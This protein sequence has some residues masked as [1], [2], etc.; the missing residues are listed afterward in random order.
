V[1]A[2]ILRLA[3]E[4]PRWGYRRIQGELKKLGVSVSATTIR[5]VLLGNGLRP[6]LLRY[7]ESGHGEAAIAV[8]AQIAR[9]SSSKATASRWFVGSP[10]A[11][12]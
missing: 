8:W 6:A 12:S 2:L 9:A 3:R 1:V 11:S 5:T 10:V 7:A 4:N